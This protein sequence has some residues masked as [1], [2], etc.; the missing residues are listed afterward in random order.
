MAIV[1]PIKGLRYNPALISNLKEGRDTPRTT[2]LMPP[3][4]KKYYKCSPYNIIRLE[5]GK[6]LPGDNESC[7]RYTRAAA[8]FK[9]WLESRVLTPRKQSCPLLIRAKSLP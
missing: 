3:P 2:S 4:R 8:D 9:S 1:I 5:Y 7:N 6:D